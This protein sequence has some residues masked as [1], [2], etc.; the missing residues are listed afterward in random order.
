VIL[1]LRT[2]HAPRK[3]PANDSAAQVRHAD[4]RRIG[5]TG[6][7]RHRV[8]EQ[9]VSA[10]VT[11]VTPLNGSTAAYDTAQSRIQL[12]AAVVRP[13][14]LLL[15]LLL[16][17]MQGKAA[18]MFIGSTGHVLPMPHVKLGFRV[19][20]CRPGADDSASAPR[21]QPSPEQREEEEDEGRANE[22]R[23]GVPR[24]TVGH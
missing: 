13:V 19:C 6:T 17:L 16:L 23:K 15:L 9:V 1:S 12:E 22:Q 20:K 24:A 2:L 18:D 21:M 8:V 10:A 5:I 7:D 4:D 14:L 11:A 3:R